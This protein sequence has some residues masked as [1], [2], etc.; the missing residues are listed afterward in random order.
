MHAFVSQT[1][2]REAKEAMKAKAKELQRARKDA[3]RR[4]IKAPGFG[5]M[6]GSM[7]G[8]GRS[9]VPVTETFNPEPTKPAYTPPR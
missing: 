9:D 2:E 5:G 1:Q 7:G 6:G 4:G 3:Q 8:Y